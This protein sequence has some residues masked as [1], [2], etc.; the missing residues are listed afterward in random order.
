MYARLHISMH[1]QEPDIV[2]VMVRYVMANI[3]NVIVLLTMCGVEVRV[4]VIVPLSIHVVERDIVREVEYR[5]EENIRVAIARVIIVGMVVHVFIIILIHVFQDIQLH[6]QMDIMQHLQNVVFAEEPQEHVMLVAQPVINT[7]VPEQDIP[8]VVA[9]LA[10]V[11][12]LLVV[13]Q[14]VISGMVALV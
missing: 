3:P 14:A 1:V 6:V 4:F 2:P 8:E 5:V 11:N 7:I 9:V 13:V 10:M 12:I